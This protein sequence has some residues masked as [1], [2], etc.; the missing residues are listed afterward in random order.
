MPKNWRDRLDAQAKHD[1]QN[2]TKK[3][4]TYKQSYRQAENPAIA[5][6]WIA[7]VEILRSMKNLEK[8]MESMEKLHFEDRKKESVIKDLEKW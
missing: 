6:L 4:V 1:L 3:T 8:R 7:L 2:M 5:Q